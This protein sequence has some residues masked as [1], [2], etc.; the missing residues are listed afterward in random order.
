VRFLLLK[1]LKESDELPAMFLL[2]SE[3]FDTE[4]LCDVIYP[5]AE[6]DNLIVLIARE[7]FCL[8]NPTDC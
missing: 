8:N 2:I 7:I 6:A 5:I 3:E 4:V 1:F